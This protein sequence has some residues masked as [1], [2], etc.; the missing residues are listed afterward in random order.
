MYQKYYKLGLDHFINKKLLEDLPLF[1][2]DKIS[3]I[4]DNSDQSKIADLVNAR[5][6]NHKNLITASCLNLEEKY[7]KI[8]YRK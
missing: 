5:N 2:K 4:E 1:W 7:I 8:G 6:L 3:I